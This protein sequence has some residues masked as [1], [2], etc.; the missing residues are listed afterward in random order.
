MQHEYEG[1]RQEL[2]S[3]QDNGTKQLDMLH[4]QHEISSA[5]IKQMKNQL[6]EVEKTVMSRTR[7]LENNYVTINSSKWVR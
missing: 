3:L 6:L 5:M 4:E 2:D 7:E 1:I